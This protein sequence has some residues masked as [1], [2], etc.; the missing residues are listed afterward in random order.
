MKLRQEVNK[1]IRS[2][3]PCAIAKPTTKKQGIYTPLPTP[4]RAW[5]SISMEYMLGLPSTKRGNDCVFVVVDRFSKMTIL[6]TWKKRITA[7]ATTKIF[8]EQVWVRFRIPQTIVSYRDNHFLITFWS[9]LWSLLDTKLTNS[10]TF[11]PRTNGQTKVINSMIV[12]ILCMYNSKHSHT[13]D[14]SFLYVQ[15]S[16]KQ[17]LLSSTDHNPF[18]VGLGFQPLGPIDVALPFVVTSI[19]SSPA[20]NEVDKATYFIERIQHIRQ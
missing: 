7:E 2:C 8:F 17:A 11:H 5:E 9:N 12:H 6:V 3:T 14:E 10:M 15:H 1:C 18:Q 20:P 19:D 16:Y 13:W 4:F